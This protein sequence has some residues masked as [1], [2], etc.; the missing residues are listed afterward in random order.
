MAGHGVFRWEGVTMEWRP[1]GGKDPSNAIILMTGSAV[2]RHYE[3]DVKGRQVTKRV[4]GAAALATYTPAVTTNVVT[5]A[6][7]GMVRKQ[8]AAF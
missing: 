2:N 3:L 6:R 4:T 5:K 8:P 1:S 7:V